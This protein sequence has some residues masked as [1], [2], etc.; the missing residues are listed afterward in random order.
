MVCAAYIPIK[1]SSFIQMAIFGDKL[2]S[3]LLIKVLAH[4]SHIRNRMSKWKFHL[5][6]LICIWFAIPSRNKKKRNN[7]RTPNECVCT[8]ATIPVVSSSLYGCR[9]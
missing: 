6:I 9:L 2:S 3:N 5:G 7:F 4:G 1:M 8:F